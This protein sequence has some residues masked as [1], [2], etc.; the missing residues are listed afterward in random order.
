[1]LF[2]VDNTGREHCDLH[3]RPIGPSIAIPGPDIK[4]ESDLTCYL[5]DDD[6]C[7]SLSSSTKG[8]YLYRTMILDTG[9]NTQLQSSEINPYLS[10][11]TNSNFCAWI[12]WT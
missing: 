7:D 5:V 1:M 11:V 12:C 9:C 4:L 10:D 2:A 8:K 3:E 6:N